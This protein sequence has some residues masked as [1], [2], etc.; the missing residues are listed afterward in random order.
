[1]SGEISAQWIVSIILAVA[2][3]ALKRMVDKQDVEIA[4]LREEIRQDRESHRAEMDEM[5]SN[6]VG[7]FEELKDIH[8]AGMAAI[9]RELAAGAVMFAEIKADVKQI[10][11][12]CAY[13]PKPHSPQQ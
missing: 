2:A 11:Q 8:T 1:M 10:K 12:A 7:R 9:M 13:L 4:K 6:Y 5:R 3:W